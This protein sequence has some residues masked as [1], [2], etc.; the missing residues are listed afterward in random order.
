[1]CAKLLQSAGPA[2]RPAVHHDN[3]SRG[4]A[5]SVRVAGV[6]GVNVQVG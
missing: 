2:D 3:H 1:L 4:A 6:V 5:S